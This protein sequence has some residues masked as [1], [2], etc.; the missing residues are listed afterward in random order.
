ME[1]LHGE[2][3]SQNAEA[4]EHIAHQVH[5]WANA[6]RE[7][8]GQNYTTSQPIPREF[9]PPGT[10]STLPQRKAK[11]KAKRRALT[12]AEISRTEK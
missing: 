12:G 7:E 1:Q 9:A 11:G 3:A 6:L 5:G 2:V 8:F 4:A 10:A